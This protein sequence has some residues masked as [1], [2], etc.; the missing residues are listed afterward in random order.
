[1]STQA[2]TLAH[3]AAAQTIAEMVRSLARS[4]AR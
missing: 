3:P 1:M 2:R 4:P